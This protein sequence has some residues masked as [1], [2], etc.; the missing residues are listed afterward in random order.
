MTE[1]LF[2][3]ADAVRALRQELVEAANDAKHNDIRFEVGPI[4]MEFQVVATKESTKN[5]EISFK[6]FGQGVSG[7]IG[8]KQSGQET[9]KVKLVLTPRLIDENGNRKERG[10]EISD[11][12]SPSKKRHSSG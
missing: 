11:T 1:E 3:L 5:G 8:G 7:G 6:I 12:K 10:L 9:Q 4:E 2:P